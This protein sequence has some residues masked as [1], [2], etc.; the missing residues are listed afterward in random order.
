MALPSPFYLS[1]PA[2]RA[3]LLGQLDPNPV[4][5]VQSQ[6]VRP[7]AVCHVGEDPGPVLELDPEH[8]VR[9]RFQNDPVDQPHGIG[10]L[11]HEL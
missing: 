10:G 2:P 8:A 9:K 6:E 5:R 1:Y 7:D 3:V 11:G 4:T